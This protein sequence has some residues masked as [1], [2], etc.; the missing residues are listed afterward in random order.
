MNKEFQSTTYLFLF[1]AFCSAIAYFCQTTSEKGASSEF[2]TNAINCLAVCLAKDSTNV[3]YLWAA[4]SIYKLPMGKSL[5]SWPYFSC[6]RNEVNFPCKVCKSRTPLTLVG[7]W[8]GGGVCRLVGVVV[9]RNGPDHQPGFLTLSLLKP[10]M[11][12]LKC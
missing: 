2:Q 7:I 8:M 9:G 11:E 1:T 10:A 4:S 3:T 5:R 12:T 6:L